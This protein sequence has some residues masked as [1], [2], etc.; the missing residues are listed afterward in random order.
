MD[1]GMEGV[2]ASPLW[3]RHWTKGS[4]HE[5]FVFIVYAQKRPLNAHTGVSGG[6][7]GLNFGFSFHLDPYFVYASSEGAAESMHFCKLFET[8]VVPSL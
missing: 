8:C 2:R 5:I 1:G 7:R 4:A 6:A 3:I